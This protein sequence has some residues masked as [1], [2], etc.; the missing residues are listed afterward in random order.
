V[1]LNGKDKPVV[2]EVSND[3]AMA[4]MQDFIAAVR[5]RKQPTCTVEDAFRSTATVQLAMIALQSESKVKWDAA[6]REII[7]NSAAAQ[8]LKREYRAPYQH[9]YKG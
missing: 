2:T 6:K 9:P 1:V 4:H 8:L 5:S 3:A 7:G